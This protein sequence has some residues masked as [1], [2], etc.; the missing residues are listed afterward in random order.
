MTTINPETTLDV[1]VPV[2]VT[3]HPDGTREVRVDF[4]GAPWM[5]VNDGGNVWDTETEE[6]MTERA[7][8]EEAEIYLHRLLSTLDTTLDRLVDTLRDV[9]KV[10]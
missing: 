8:E 9:G 7:I 2:C 1:Y 10:P 6:W 3:L 4:E 5:Y